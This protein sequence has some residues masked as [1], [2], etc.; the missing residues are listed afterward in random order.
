[1]LLDACLIVRGALEYNSSMKNKKAKALANI[2]AH[3]KKYLVKQKPAQYTAKDHAVWRFILRE[4]THFHFLNA[5]PSYKTGLKKTGITLDRIPSIENIDRCLKKM[6]WRAAGV[7]GFIPP[8]AFLEL[9]ALC[10]LPIATEMRRIEH[11]EYTPAPDIVHEAAGHAPMISDPKFS[12]YLK[13]YA[14]IAKHAIIT[15]RDMDQ[16]AAIRELSDLKEHPKATPELI[17]TAYSKL[18]QANKAMTK[19]TEAT[20]LS[21]MAWWTTE[22]G[23]I[24]DLDNAKIY[25]AGLLSSVGES[26]HCLSNK[27]RRIPFS[28]NCTRYSYDITDP[29]P[30]L[31]VAKDFADLEKGLE[32]LSQ[33]LSYKKGGQLG[34][35]RMLDAETVNTIELN[36]GLQISGVLKKF[37]AISEAPDGVAYVQLQGPTQLQYK[38]KLIPGHGKKY[39]SHGYGTPLGYLKGAQ[40]CL[41]EMSKKELE[42]FQIRLKEKV[43]LN[44]VS[45]VQVSGRLKAILQHNRKNLIFTFSDCTVKY[46]NELL[47]QP[48]WGLF[49]MAAGINVTSVFGGAADRRAYG[50][51]DDFVAQKIPPKK[52]S[53]EQKALFAGYQQTSNWRRN[54]KYL[55][56]DLQTLWQRSQ[57][58]FQEAWL[59]RFEILELAYMKK[60]KEPW[61][62]DL[63]REIVL[64]SQKWPNLV[65]YVL[66]S[67][68]LI[69]PTL[70]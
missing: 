5:H 46:K 48:E 64:I 31:F 14:E 23:L 59:L 15:K 30:Q 40:K 18:E 13:K 11:L 60:I 39:H 3:L 67:L 25:G 53:A 62:E 19:I 61:L 7:S 44:F 16:Y 24:G 50:E 10:I 51:T 42:S 8:A 27:V 20:I 70:L 69:K 52:Y 22:Y 57:K 43:Q 47:F 68:R 35:G 36:S 56:R 55:S 32:A 17:E 33:E 65:P 28:V 34:L 4:L 6:G 1:M 37:E 29:Q 66:N 9:Q 38:N 54:K 63:E 26:R 49:D 41:S 58:E 12:R 2:P 45:G 21:R